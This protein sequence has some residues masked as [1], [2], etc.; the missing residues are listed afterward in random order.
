M[1][2]THTHTHKRTPDSM[3]QAQTIQNHGRDHCI[4]QIAVNWVHWGL[5]GGAGSG[6][7]SAQ[8]LLYRRA[9]QRAVHHAHGN[10]TSARRAQRSVRI[11]HRKPAHCAI[12]RGHCSRSTHFPAARGNKLAQRHCGVICIH[13]KVAQAGEQRCGG[14]LSGSIK[15]IGHRHVHVALPAA[16][17]NITHKDV[18]EK[19]A[20]AGGGIGSK[21]NRPACWQRGELNG[22]APR[23]VCRGLQRSATQGN[24]HPRA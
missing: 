16:Q 23:G 10:V 5:C 1:A 7:R 24:V 17:N 15:G 21:G 20:G 6:S 14:C 4:I 11:P 8:P 2:H 3:R 12:A 18:L 19:R 22:P 9:P 13:C